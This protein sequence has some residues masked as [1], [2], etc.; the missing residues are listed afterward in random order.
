MNVL[1]KIRALL[2][3]AESKSAWLLLFLMLLGMMLET[4]S[5]GLVVPL[6]AVVVSDDLYIKGSAVYPILQFL[7]SPSKSQLIVMVMIG[8]MSVYLVKNM[9]LAF[10]AWRQVNFTYNFQVNLS[11]R[12]FA[13]YLKQ[14]YAFH[15]QRNSSQLIRNVGSGVG[16][17]SN[18]I[19]NSMTIITEGMVLTAIICLLLAVEPLG[20]LIVVFFL[21]VTGFLYYTVTKAKIAKWGASK[22]FHDL[23]RL[24]H[25]RQGLGGVKEVKLLGR[26]SGFLKDFHEHNFAT[27]NASKLQV[28]F[29]Q[30]PRLIF[31]LLAVF[32]LAILVISMLNEQHE[33]ASIVP[34][35]GLF[36]AA[37]FRL[38][39]SANRFLAAQQGLRFAAPAVNTIYQEILLPEPSST[40]KMNK[41]YQFKH[42]ISLI[43]IKFS[44][45]NSETIVVNDLSMEI[46][47]G[48][49]IGLIGPSGSGKSTFVD[50]FLGL[51][52]PDSGRILVDG[53]DVMED[54]RQWQNQI[55]YVP[56]AI[57][58][59]DD[60][61]RRNVAFGLPNEQI[62]D[63]AVKHAIK[64]AQLDAFVESLV[65]GLETKVGERGVRLSGGQRQRIGIARALYHD[66]SILV[67]D[68][69][70]SALDTD[71][72]KLVMKTITALQS[73]KTIIIV[74]HRLTTVKDCNKLYSM[75]NGDLIEKKLI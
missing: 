22:Q 68:E 21:S 54:V 42:Q 31:E 3:P 53:L 2:T 19:S 16:L 45:D 55:G 62:D 70:T 28:T 56:Q 13:L 75:E 49:A 48:D 37:A 73:D 12:L 20:S 59:S 41:T 26:E 33:I 34:V 17:T 15:L 11:Q 23:L 14:P 5:I 65:D 44:Y 72:E 1:D 25:L 30:F 61:L 60:T 39:P 40:H 7:G 64:A 74:A 50:L 67:F 66:P 9:F 27:T 29:Q 52:S 24:Q 32:G 18:A 57:F 69:A 51:L 36:A 63:D 8:F 35:L 47:K 71:T 43:N 38:M 6:L 46:K 58:L 4:L 10:L